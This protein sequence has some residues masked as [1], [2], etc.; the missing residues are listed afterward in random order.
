MV[1]SYINNHLYS[2]FLQ[3]TGKRPQLDT[4]TAAAWQDLCMLMIKKALKSIFTMDLSAYSLPPERTICIADTI[5]WFF[6]ICTIL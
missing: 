6:S 5:Y 1:F 2:G 4:G 3:H